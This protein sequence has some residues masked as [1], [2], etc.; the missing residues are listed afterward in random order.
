MTEPVAYKDK[1]QAHDRRLA[2][3]N[4]LTARGRVDAS[5]KSSLQAAVL[6]LSSIEPLRVTTPDLF[7]TRIVVGRVVYIL[8][9]NLGRIVG[10][11]ILLPSNIY[12]CRQHRHVVLL[13]VPEIV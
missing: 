6:T 7:A 2:K 12:P 4:A 8:K 11:T 3:T 9:G 13:L 1:A 10:G 5:D